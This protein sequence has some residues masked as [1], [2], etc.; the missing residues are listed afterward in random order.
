MCL[1]TQSII[2]FISLLTPEI[3]KPSPSQIVIE[4]EAGAVTWTNYGDQWCTKEP[5]AEDAAPDL[6]AD[7]QAI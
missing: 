6:L 5:P 2:L 4:A 1:T 7:N 3:V